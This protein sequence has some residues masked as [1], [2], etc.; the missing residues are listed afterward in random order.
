VKRGGSPRP[1]QGLPNLVWAL[2]VTHFTS[3]AGGLVRSFLVL[4]L[5]QEQRLSLATGAEANEPA[6]PERK[7]T[8]LELRVPEAVSGS[9]S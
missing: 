7:V 8:Q 4:Y 5:T 1:R 6:Q 3:A 9:A 2:A